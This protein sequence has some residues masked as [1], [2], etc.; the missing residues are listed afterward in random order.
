MFINNLRLHRNL[1]LYQQIYNFNHLT[2]VIA[3]SSWLNTDINTENDISNIKQTEFLLNTYNVN[4]FY[5]ELKDIWLKLIS[6]PAKQFNHLLQQTLL[7]LI[8]HDKSLP[9]DSKKRLLIQEIFELSSFKDIFSNNN[10]LIKMNIPSLKISLLNN[11]NFISISSNEILT[12][13]YKTKN[14]AMFERLKFRFEKDL[15]SDPEIIDF[16]TQISNENIEKALL[17]TAKKYFAN[18]FTN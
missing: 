14:L 7:F 3:H 6:L 8:S 4:S 9:L 18:F 13:I 5:H 1:N 12:S 11:K 16:F 17:F 15:Q 2:S 10:I